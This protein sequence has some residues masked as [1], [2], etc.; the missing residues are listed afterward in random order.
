MASVEEQI[1]HDFDEEIG[2][3]S[4][5]LGRKVSNFGVEMTLE[6]NTTMLR[7]IL[8]RSIMSLHFVLSKEKICLM[9]PFGPL[10]LLLHYLTGNQNIMFYLGLLGM[11]PLGDRL[12]Y[13]SKELAYYTRPIVRV[14]LLAIF[15]NAT[16]MIISIH[17]LRNGM[18]S[19]VRESLLG[20]VLSNLLLIPG[21]A[22]FTGGI[23]HSM[24]LQYFSKASATARSG[25]LLMAVMGIMFPNVLHFT[26]TG[27][28]FGKSELFLSRFSSCIMLVAYACYLHFQFQIKQSLD[29]TL[30]LEEVDEEEVCG[31]SKW[32]AIGWLAL[33][34]AWTFV[35][36]KHLVDAI[37]VASES[38]NIPQAVITGIILP[39]V[40][41]ASAI[42]FAMKDKMDITLEDAVGSSI[43]LIM[44]VMPFSVL[45]GWFMGLWLD[46]NFPLFQTA[47]LLMS[48]LISAY[49]LQ[50]GFS[51]YLK[52]LMLLLCYL[53][54]VASFL[55]HV[56]PDSED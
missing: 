36:T 20:S 45:V 9:L 30:T 27:V 22:F 23:V 24:R 14:Y 42:M 13:A 32:E 12:N 35:L 50:E 55:V 18:L 51:H 39:L 2:S 6:A 53:I 54:V 16:D 44:F 29:D 37:Q 28:H 11:I 3:G 10:A 4:I 5:E 40:E 34:I 47:V 7:K 41:R 21:C 48:V 17:A 26:H 31:L 46:L 49:V 8:I 43:R 33:L 52:G 19:T 25:L 1:D 15:S 56:E 38:T